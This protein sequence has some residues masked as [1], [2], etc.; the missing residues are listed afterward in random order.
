MADDLRVTFYTMLYIKNKNFHEN[1]A[2]N[3]FVTIPGYINCCKVLHDS[4]EKTGFKLT[5]LT[6]E[7]AVIT[8][9]ADNLNVEEVN[10][11][12]NIPENIRFF[13]A[14]HKIEVFKYLS[15]SGDD[16]SIL[17]DSDVVCINNIPENMEKI[18]QEKIPVYYDITD[19]VYPAY[20]RIK[21]MDDKS[22]VMGIKSLGN[23]AGGE[24]IGGDK[25]FFAEI[26]KKCMEYWESY[27]CH[28]AKLHHQG[29]EMLT[30]CAI[31]KYILEGNIIFNAGSI[32][33]I[34]RYWS[35]K[36][37]HIGKPFE[38][39][40]D[41]CLLHLPA[42]KE[43]LAKYNGNNVFIEEYKTYLKNRK[44]VNIIRIMKKYIKKILLGL[45]N[46]VYSQNVRRNKN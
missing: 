41:N 32:G 10:F 38:A 12:Q 3:G 43:Y 31:E 37:L 1:A 26:Y 2:E 15:L 35:V 5:I 33:C 34:G 44:K 19:Q 9:R 11:K 18:I 16:Y 45:K 46:V 4:L 17:L 39:Y 27:I 13:S 14:H 21:V 22:L 24:F 36:T 29:D 28:I 20:G 42:D 40:L 8:E 30:S 23:W 7:P 6:N 25:K